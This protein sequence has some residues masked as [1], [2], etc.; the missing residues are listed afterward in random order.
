M[1]TA[2]F[3]GNRGLADPLSDL[4][5]QE[6]AS[7]WAAAGSCSLGPIPAFPPRQPDPIR[8]SAP[9]NRLQAHLC[10]STAQAVSRSLLSALAP[11]L[12][13]PKWGTP[14]WIC[15]RVREETGNSRIRRSRCSSSS[16]RRH[17]GLSLGSRFA[18]GFDGRRG[19]CIFTEGAGSADNQG[20]VAIALASGELPGGTES[21]A[22]EEMLE[23]ELIR[24][25]WISDCVVRFGSHCS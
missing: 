24:W 23:A 17:I 6:T 15:G 21:W 20:I 7:W 5:S 9:R 1:R 16:R 14:W 10:H 13:V 19:V 11:C 3:G 12:V 2:E 8:R 4:A 18:G 22:V 25:C